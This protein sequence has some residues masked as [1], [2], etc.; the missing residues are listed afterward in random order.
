MPEFKKQKPLLKETTG[1]GGRVT[2]G[3]RQQAIDSRP[4][5]NKQMMLFHL[6]VHSSPFLLLAAHI[7]L[8]PT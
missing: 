6:C 8:R 4:D 5:L 2:T 7:P 1:W 3:G